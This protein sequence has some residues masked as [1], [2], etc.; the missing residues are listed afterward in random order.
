[1]VRVLQVLALFAMACFTDTVSYTPQQDEAAMA[2]IAQTYQQAGP[3]GLVLSICED[4]AR[5]DPWQPTGSDCQ[6]G[7]VVKGGGRGVA[8]TEEHGNVGCGGCPFAT[9]AYVRAT[10]DGPALGGPVSLGGEVVLGDDNAPYTLPFTISLAC[11]DPNAPCE[12]SGVINVDGSITATLVVGTGSTAVTTGY[13]L[14]SAGQ[15]ACP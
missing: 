10:A 2:T 6:V 15:A 12:L 14:S 4:T 11:E 9:V 5:S 3:D 1:V 7:H 13:G 8:H